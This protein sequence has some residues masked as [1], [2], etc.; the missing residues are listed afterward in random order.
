[1][2]LNNKLYDALKWF[3]LIAL[4]A[5]GT[6]YTGFAQVWS[7]PYASQIS[8]STVILVLLLGALLGV[9]TANFNKATL[10][11]N[12]TPSRIDGVMHVDSSDPEKD[13]FSFELFE[14]PE[15]FPERDTLTFKVSKTSP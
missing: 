6:A 9:S 4:P 5:F 13:V 7:L 15:G 2:Q 12:T 14:A 8:Q 3:T 1:M 11:P 10:A